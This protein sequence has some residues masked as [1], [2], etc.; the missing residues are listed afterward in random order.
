[1]STTQNLNMIAEIITNQLW[2]MNHSRVSHK[3]DSSRR[4][5]K[6]REHDRPTIINRQECDESKACDN[7][8]F[9]GRDNQ[10]EAFSRSRPMRWLTRTPNTDCNAHYTPNINSSPKEPKHR[11]EARTRRRTRPLRQN[12]ITERDHSQPSRLVHEVQL[13]SDPKTEPPH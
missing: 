10:S 11:R 3:L 4:V 5:V 2:I 7:T 13:D 12:E 8:K 1:M 9:I 6:Q